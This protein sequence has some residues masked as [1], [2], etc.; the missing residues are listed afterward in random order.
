MFFK[1]IYRLLWYNFLYQ[2]I[3]DIIITHY[4]S[5]K[6]S[7]LTSF[8]TKK[9]RRCRDEISLCP[10]HPL[11]NFSFWQRLLVC[12]VFSEASRTCIF[13]LKQLTSRCSKNV[14]F[15][16]LTVNTGHAIFSGEIYYY[17]PLN[18]VDKTLVKH[19]FSLQ[20]LI[21]KYV[22]FNRYFDSN[23]FYI[24]L[25]RYFEICVTNDFLVYSGVSCFKSVE[26]RHSYIRLYS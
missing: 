21:W 24:Y 12:Q 7:K 23:N 10:D 4:P 22:G 6:P 8:D 2:N 3:N 18:S 16:K 17:W 13:C 5:Q 26:L 1:N 9:G 14:S 11:P 20:N 15:I 25:K 19:R